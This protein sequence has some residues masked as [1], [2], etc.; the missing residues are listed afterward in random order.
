[1]H[2]RSPPPDSCKKSAWRHPQAYV[3]I[4]TTTPGSKK[5]GILVRWVS[6]NI[7]NEDTQVWPANYCAINIWKKS[8][9]N[10]QDIEYLASPKHFLLP[11][12]WVYV[13]PYINGE[14]TYP[15]KSHENITKKEMSLFMPSMLRVSLPSNPWWGSSPQSA[16]GNKSDLSA[17][18]W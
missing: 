15:Y 11:G 14:S 17:L 6:G 18:H 5:H 10:K 9:D 2:D 12:L 4:Y 1:M 8:I 13:Y 7:Q 16:G 3:H